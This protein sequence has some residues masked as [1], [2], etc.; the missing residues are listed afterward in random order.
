MTPPPPLH[1]LY[2][3][4]VG[5]CNLSCAHCWIEPVR[6][7]TPFEV[8][9]RIEGE[10]TPEQLSRLVG[11]ALPLGLHSVKFTGGEPLLRSDF[12]D[13]YRSVTQMG[14]SILLETNGTLVPPGL[15]EVFEATPPEAVAVS[16]D[17]VDPA[18]HDSFRM[19]RGA[20][21][22]SREFIDRLVDM[23][24]TV[25]VIMSVLSSELA[26]VA[27]MAML[28]R[29][30]GVSSLKVNPVQPMGRGRQLRTGDSYVHGMIDLARIVHARLGMAVT[31]DVPPAFVPVDRLKR[32]SR[33]PVLNLLGILPDGRVSFCGIGFS[34]PSL[35]MGN[36]TE[37]SLA[38]IWENSPILAR[39]RV[40]VPAKLEGICSACIHRVTCMGKCVMQNRAGAGSFTSPHWL[41][42]EADERGFFPD[43]RRVPENA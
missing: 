5:E 39:L 4:P 13:L 37:E 36:I 27:D 38:G 1:H 40:E 32:L 9:E 21:R 10:I 29:E 33:C 23:D 6:S 34:V 12:P 31:V 3:N 11:E 43:S 24:I 22:R 18:I 30:T 26:P 25:Q 15:W 7:V 16:L 17:S 41:C 20:W 14:P 35:V 19:S 8:R 42:S 2:V 28:C